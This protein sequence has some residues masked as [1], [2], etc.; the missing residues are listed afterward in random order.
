MALLSAPS[1][2]SLQQWFPTWG[3][4]KHLAGYVKLGEE[5]YFV[6]NPE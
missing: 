4:L 6:I 1:V 2:Y 5:Y 3:T